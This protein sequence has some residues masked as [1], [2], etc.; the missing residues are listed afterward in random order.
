MNKPRK[1]TIEKYTEFL[2]D[3]S[4]T[5]SISKADFYQRI[6]D[7][8]LNNGITSHMRALGYLESMN[9]DTFKIGLLKVMPIH[10]VQLLNSLNNARV[11]AANSKTTDI[12]KSATITAKN[13]VNKKAVALVSS[14]KPVKQFSILWGAL[15]IKW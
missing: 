5:S 14:D 13:K 7:Y 8:R 10:A 6:R 4:K 11:I 12:A 1:Q 2:E 15:I 3:L 9:K